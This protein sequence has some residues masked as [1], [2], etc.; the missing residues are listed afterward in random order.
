VEIRWFQAFAF[1][2]SLYRYAEEP[3]MR[4]RVVYPENYSRLSPHTSLAVGLYK[5]NSVDPQRL[6]A[7]GLNLEAIT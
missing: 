3:H 4:Y 1:T 5:L 7:P 6:R 2:C